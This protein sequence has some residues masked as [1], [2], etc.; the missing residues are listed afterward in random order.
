MNYEDFFPPIIVGTFND[1]TTDKV[2]TQVLQETVAD[3]EATIRIYIDSDGGY[4]DS[5]A[6]IVELLET[7][8]NPIHTICL[9]RAMSAGAFLLSMGDERFIG[10]HSSVMIHELSDGITGHVK[11]ILN[12]AREADRSNRHWVNFL[13]KNCGTDFET[14]QKRLRR[15]AHRDLFL[16]AVDAKSF[17]IVDHIGLPKFDLKLKKA[18]RRGRK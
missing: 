12:H 4:I 13:A 9:G 10:K 16:N 6:T 14:I 15:V 2:V 11:E 18:K 3:P 8:P 1:A 7:V 5:L 17:G